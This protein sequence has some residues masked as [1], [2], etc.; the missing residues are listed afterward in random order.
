MRSSSIFITF[1][2]AVLALPQGSRNA[3]QDTDQSVDRAFFPSPK[4]A[5]GTKMITTA[6]AVVQSGVDDLDISVNRVRGP[7][8]ASALPELATKG[9]GLGAMISTQQAKIETAPDIDLGG[10][11]DVKTSSQDLG[12]SL[13]KLSDDLILAEPVVRQAGLN[14]AVVDVLRQQQASSGALVRTVVGKL[15]KTAQGLAKEQ[16]DGLMESLNR[17]IVVYQQGAIA[18][19]APAPLPPAAPGRPAARRT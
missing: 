12:K 6:L 11:L 2:A 3:I 16:S 9:S 13:N 8:G 5:K 14:S 17:V 4:T 18:A 19:P 1:A 10:A 15:P 7:E